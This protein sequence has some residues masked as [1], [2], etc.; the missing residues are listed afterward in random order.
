M[1]QHFYAI[2]IKKN[3]DIKSGN[4]LTVQIQAAQV[5]NPLKTAV[6]RVEVELLDINDNKPQFEVDLYNISIVENL[7]N[8][9]SVLQVMATDQDQVCTPK[10]SYISYINKKQT[11]CQILCPS[12]GKHSLFVTT[13]LSILRL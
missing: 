6:A 10:H 12:M 4:T 8:G 1:I 7:P 3:Q 2:P 11:C 13:F 5:N 9:F